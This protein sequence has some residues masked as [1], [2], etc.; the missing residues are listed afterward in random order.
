MSSDLADVLGTQ[1]TCNLE[2]KREIKDLG[3]I[4]KAI[5]ALANDLNGKGGGDLIIGVDSAGNPVDDVDTSDAALLRLTNLR[6]EGKILDRPSITVEA[7]TYRGK[8]VI[9]V[10]VEASHTP[11]VRL[12]GIAW[13]RPGPS[14]QRATADD[15][16]ILI[17]RRRSF[18]QPF[19]SHPVL[20]SGLQDLDL[21]LFRSTYLPSAVSPV[22]V[23]ENGRPLEQQL[24]SLRLTDPSGIPTVLGLLAVGFDPT[25][26]IAGAYLQFARFQGIDM[27]APVID[28]VE[29]RYNVIDMGKP[30]EALIKSN[31]RTRL[32][33][34]DG[35]REEPHSD[36]P[37]AALREA[38]MNALMHRNYES[39]N[40][41]TRVLWFDD[42]IEISNPGGPYGQVRT[43]NFDRVNDYRNPSL[44]AAM[45]S[46]G[47]VN[48]FGRGIRR[49]RESMADNGN[50]PPEFIIDDASW[51]VVL[52]SS[53]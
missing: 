27:E 18:T 53:I 42:R 5:C 29:L 21:E 38:C 48:R 25:S 24:A 30:L 19:D 14:T 7:A 10:H 51:A 47:Y 28:E 9:R 11:P 50:P 3:V 15:E 23:E 20:G 6:D 35:L 34:V 49:I 4:R 17:E 37:M 46:L 40:A 22:V 13:V 32:V 52:R 12:D 36:Y 44:A 2:F 8:S 1:E 31:L 43:D 16:R 26:F 39:S 45:K 33:E 41:P